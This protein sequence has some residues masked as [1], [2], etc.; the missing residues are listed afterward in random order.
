M[1]AGEQQAWSSWVAATNE[2]RLGN[3]S[4]YTGFS[5][6]FNLEAQGQRTA[7]LGAERPNASLLVGHLLLYAHMT[8]PWHLVW[9]GLW[10]AA[11]G[12]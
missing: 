11:G 4:T 1:Y 10:V 9:V 3:L 7:N 5:E 6:L 12:L 8:H 2:H